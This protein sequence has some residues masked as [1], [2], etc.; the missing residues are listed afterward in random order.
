MRYKLHTKI[1]KEVDGHVA[2]SFLFFFLLLASCKPFG[3]SCI[4][5]AQ[6]L[7]FFIK[8][9]ANNSIYYHTVEHFH[10]NFDFVFF[11]SISV[12]C[13]FR[14]VM[15]SHFLFFPLMLMGYL[16]LGNFFWPYYQMQNEYSLEYNT[17]SISKVEKQSF[18][19][20]NGIDEM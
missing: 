18:Y 8:K 10:C 1:V 20:V 3:W 15:V 17:F 7:P 9:N 12:E 2:Y 14:R 16:Q 11:F 6:F 5:Y 13:C 4:F 19:I